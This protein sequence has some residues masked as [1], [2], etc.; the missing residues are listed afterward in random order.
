MS[1]DHCQVLGQLCTGPRVPTLDRFMSSSGLSGN[2]TMSEI[3]SQWRSRMP[4]LKSVCT[5][6]RCSLNSSTRF[7]TCTTSSCVDVR[8]QSP[9]RSNEMMNCRHINRITFVQEIEKPIVLSILLFL[10][11]I[12]NFFGFRETSP[13]GAPNSP[14]VHF[15]LTSRF[16]QTKMAFEVVFG[17]CLSAT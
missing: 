8:R 11:S 3:C 5:S 6:G 7:F 10:R 14:L 13:E 12:Q 4:G 15:C 17:F 2:P 1:T 9:L 16:E